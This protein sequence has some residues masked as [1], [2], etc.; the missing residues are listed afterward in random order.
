MNCFST[1]AKA[2]TFGHSDLQPDCSKHRCKAEL[3][4]RP[5]I[6]PVAVSLSSKFSS[7]RELKIPDVTKEVKQKD[8]LM[9]GKVF[10]S[11]GK[12]VKL[13]K[14]NNSKALGSP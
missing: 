7:L 13:W 3:K 2:R 6:P 8:V 11:A 1:Q 4:G 14:L 12:L 5:H 10:H 9:G